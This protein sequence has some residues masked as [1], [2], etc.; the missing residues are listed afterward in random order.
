ML[1]AQQVKLMRDPQIKGLPCELVTPVRLVLKE[2]R[3][4]HSD[5]PCPTSPKRV[6][7]LIAPHPLSCGLGSSP[8]SF[9]CRL[10]YIVR[11]PR[12]SLPKLVS[13]VAEQLSLPI[14]EFAVESS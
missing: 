3:F 11:S 4:L 10:C 7:L 8:Y 9:L 6:E 14:N 13:M 1:I 2:T 12:H 5:L